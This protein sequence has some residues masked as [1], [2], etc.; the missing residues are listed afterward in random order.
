MPV[1]TFSR[2]VED[3]LS[4]PT[5]AHP[6]RSL[7]L[8]G[9]VRYDSMLEGAMTVAQLVQMHRA[10]PQALACAMCPLPNAWTG[11]TVRRSGRAGFTRLRNSS[12]GDGWRGLA[13][14]GR[15]EPPPPIPTASLRCGTG[16]QPV[17]TRAGSPCHTVPRGSVVAGSN[18]HGDAPGRD[19]VPFSVTGFG[20]D[21]PALAR[22]YRVF[23]S[24]GVS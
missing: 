12:R 13:Q 14:L 7:A 1:M 5:T 24:E 17:R 23:G 21:R 15:A 4:S 22:L 9:C 2:G 10:E 3:G 6:Y 18:G 19:V 11:G 8:T 20:G 16:F